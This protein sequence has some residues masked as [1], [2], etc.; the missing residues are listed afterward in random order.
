MDR[1][2]VL[3][4]PWPISEFFHFENILLSHLPKQSRVVSGFV[5]VMVGCNKELKTN[6][7]GKKEEEG[8]TSGQRSKA[9]R[10]KQKRRFKTRCRGGT[11]TDQ[12]EAERYRASQKS[13]FSPVL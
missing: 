4:F 2:L 5:L 9:G 12:S 10:N 6:S 13:C 1:I 11:G 7:Y 3:S 8:G